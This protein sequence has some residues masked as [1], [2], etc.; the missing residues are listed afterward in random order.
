MDPAAFRLKHI[1]DPREAEV[2]KAATQKLGWEPRDGNR[3]RDTNAKVMTGRG[4]ALYAGYQSYAAVACEVEV[5]RDTGQ[6]WV[7]RV[8]IGF[9]CGLVVNPVGVRAALEGQV[10]QVISRSLYEEVHF[11]EKEVTSVDWQSYRIANM[12][13]MPAQVDLVLLNRPDKPIGGAGEPVIAIVPA[14]VANA[15]FDATGVR[16]RHYPLTPDRVKKAVA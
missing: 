9:D 11:N 3:T 15:V 4:V 6:V 12:R 2:L 10:M 7:K 16:I 14:A 13:D 8:A 5:N 1:K